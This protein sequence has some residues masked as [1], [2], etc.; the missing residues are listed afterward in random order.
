MYHLTMELFKWLHSSVLIRN[1]IHVILFIKSKK[2][3]YT[4]AYVQHTPFFVR[5]KFCYHMWRNKSKRILTS[6]LLVMV[7]FQP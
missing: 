5:V 7:E 6:L 1:D 2:T 3:L 4:S